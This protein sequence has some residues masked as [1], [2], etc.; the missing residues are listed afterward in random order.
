MDSWIIAFAFFALSMSASPGPNNVMVAASGAN[1][2]FRGTLPHMFGVAVGFPI[3][4]FA[5]GLGVG[6]MLAAQP[7]VQTGL[8]VIGS[9]YLLYLAWRIARA[10]DIEVGA[11]KPRPMTFLEAAA[12]QWLNPKAWLIAVGALGTYAPTGEPLPPNLVIMGVIFIAAC[13]PS[14]GVWTLIGAGVGRMLST[15]RAM[16]VFNITMAAL[17]VASLALVF[18]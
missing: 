16:R 6:G 5:V 2:G 8:R 14:V 11:K 3:M 7:E 9:L 17:L 1:F 18:S 4:L 12:F 13:L 10:G 15:P